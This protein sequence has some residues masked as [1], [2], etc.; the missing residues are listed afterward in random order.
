MEREV[1]LA[2]SPAFRLPP[3]DD[4]GDGIVASPRAP[5]RLDT[6]YV[7]TRDLR[8]ARWGV[9]LRHRAGEGWTVKLPSKEEGPLLLVRGEFT[10]PD[11]GNRTPGQPPAEAVDLLHAYIRTARLNPVTRL[12]TVRRGA[13]LHD[14]EGHLLADVVDDEVSVLSGRRIAARFRELEVEITDEIPKGL[15]E[16][17]VGRLRIGGAGE[18][19]PTPKYVRAVGP[20][21]TLPAEVVVEK[22]SS[23][24][25]AGEVLRRA[26]A[27]SVVRLVRHDAVIRLDADP[28]GVHQARV[29]TRRLRSHL[30]TFGQLFDPELASPLRDELGWLGAALGRVRDLDVLLERLRNDVGRLPEQELD[31][32]APVLDALR[33]T[34]ETAHRALLRKLRSDRYSSLLE[35]LVGTA[36]DPGLTPEA[37]LPASATLPMVHDAWIALRK[38][39]RSASRPPTPEQLHGIR[40]RAK[41]ARYAAEAVLPFVGKPGRVYVHA[42]AALQSDLGEHN[43]AV[44]AVRWLRKWASVERG[45][46]EAF[47][48]GELVGMESAEAEAASDRWRSAWKD[49]SAKSARGWM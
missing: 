37:E 49:V 26:I 2:A 6:T 15:L 38:Q 8:L 9:S 44:I 19:D 31:A 4:L 20:V 30:R 1:K 10:F 22:L 46:A 33:K 18:P 17:V 14:P 27:D 34:R 42:V 35:R 3:L 5:E 40:I 7:D 28:E 21:A 41:R 47:V 29:A 48:A 32:A 12:R 36:A 16:T 24:P 13:Q 25:T 39:V 23:H 45:S 43:D 11:P